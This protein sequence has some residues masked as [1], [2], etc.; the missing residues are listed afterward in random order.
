MKVDTKKLDRMRVFRGLTKGQLAE[1]AG[2]SRAT[3]SVVF[4]GRFASPPTV[5]AIADSL[6]L[7]IEEVWLDPDAESQN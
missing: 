4:S 3:I 2:V 5:K 7:K 1:L 6:G